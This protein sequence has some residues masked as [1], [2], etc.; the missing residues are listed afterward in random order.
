[1]DPT[2][3]LAA[4]RPTFRA[5]AQTIVPRANELTEAEWSELEAIVADA[6]AQR[7]SS[8][9]RQLLTFIRLVNLLPVL[10]WG[11]TF[12]RLGPARRERWLRALERSRLF[13]LRRGFWGLRTLVYM[14]YYGR[15]AAHAGLRYDARLRGWLEHPDASDSARQRTLSELAAGQTTERPGPDRPDPGGEGP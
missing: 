9:R 11:R 5:L 1:M 3:S 2:A 10:R 6:L 8:V 14:G 4:V 15:P 7:P 13:L 12:R